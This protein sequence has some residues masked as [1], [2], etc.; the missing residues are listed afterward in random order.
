MLKAAKN[1]YQKVVK[2]NKL[3]REFIITNRKK[4]E[5]RQQKAV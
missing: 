2:E 1:E 3:L 5:Y 4:E